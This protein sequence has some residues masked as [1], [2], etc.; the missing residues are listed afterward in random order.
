MGT[1]ITLTDDL[2]SYVWQHGTREHPVMKKCREETAAMGPVAQMQIAPDQGGFLSLLIK[3]LDARRTLEVGVFT[4]YS[5]LAVALA[6]PSDG[7]IIALDKNEEFTQKAKAYWQEAG[8]ADKIDLRMGSG[9]DTLN[10]LIKDEQGATNFDFAFIDADKS[11]YDTYYEGA[12][13]LLRPGGIVA[14]DNVLWH[15]QVVDETDKSKDTLAIR[16]LNEKIGKDE[17]ID[18]CL[19]TIGDGLTLCRKR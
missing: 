6:L 17:R 9:I 2:I 18:I 16:A 5:S 12:L 13:K 15:G 14:I 10:A 7:R 3:L 19:T 8:I 1:S 4:G 11:S